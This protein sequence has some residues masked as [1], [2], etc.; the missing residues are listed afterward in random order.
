MAL[1]LVDILTRYQ[2]ILERFKSS[3]H[4]KYRESTLLEIDRSIREVLS[5]LDNGTL[6]DTISVKELNDLIK[7]L[8]KAQLK[9]Y[10]S[11]YTEFQKD[12]K[13]LAQDAALFESDALTE[14]TKGVTIEAAKAATAFSLAATRPLN[15]TGQLLDSFINTWATNEIRAVEAEV[16]KGYYEGKTNGELLTIIRGTKKN[17][18]KDGVLGRND[19]NAKTIIRTSVQHVAN[20]AR[21]ATWT[22]NSDIFDGYMIVATLDGR[23]TITCRSLDGKQFEIGK[24][25]VPPLHPNCRS[26]TVPMIKAKYLNP[27]EVKT[28]SSKDGY[29]NQ[30][31]TY[32][33][34]LHTQSAKFQ[35]KA[36]GPTRGKLFRDGGLDATEFARLNLGRNF[37]PLTL[38]EMRA[39]RPDIFEKAS[40]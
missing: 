32:Y 24:G 40:L 19:N 15:A 39:A 17:G 11:F 34:W 8:E 27:D 22:E 38:E 20:T 35:D 29:V 3:I 18:Y 4:G 30:K 9:V 5:K 23:T 33:E 2:V 7:S 31:T 36:L 37:E 21:M 25:P 1:P 13:E 10:R 26:T 12:L 16:R 6:S 14:V 28:R